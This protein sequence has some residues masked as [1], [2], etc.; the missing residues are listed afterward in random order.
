MIT[1]EIIEFLE[2]MLDDEIKSYKKFPTEKY[3]EGR[4]DMM[5]EVINKLEE[6]EF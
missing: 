3:Y 1:D 6:K 4:R 5:R 2:T